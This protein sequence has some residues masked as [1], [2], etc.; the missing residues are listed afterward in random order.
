M[1]LV[2][3]HAHILPFVDDG[4]RTKEQWLQVLGAYAGAGFSHVVTTVHLYNPQVTT[5]TE[6]IRPMHEWAKEEAKKRSIELL[7]G[8]ETYVGGTLDPR[9]LP[10]MDNFVLL[11]VDTQTEPLFLLHHAYGLLK[12]GYSVILAHIERYRW[13]DPDSNLVN[14]LREMG[15]YFQCNV[16]GVEKGEANRYLEI[17]LVDIIAGDNHGDP[18]QPA[19]LAALLETHGTIRRRMENLFRV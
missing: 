18:A 9:V 11:E 4:V 2:E 14:K 16:E 8:S 10:F 15:V 12:R 17:G 13:F 7:L 19:R 1:G 6:N 5:R 3:C